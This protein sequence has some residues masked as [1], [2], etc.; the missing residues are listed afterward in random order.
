VIVVSV[1]PIN[2]NNSY[3]IAQLPAELC[4]DGGCEIG[5]GS[6]ANFGKLNSNPSPLSVKADWQTGL[7][8][9][10]KNWS[11][12]FTGSPDGKKPK[13]TVD[14][15]D[16]TKTVSFESLNK[17]WNFTL[18]AKPEGSPNLNPSEVNL[19]PAIEF[20][21]SN[22]LSNINGSNGRF[23][24][25]TPLKLGTTPSTLSFSGKNDGSGV[26]VQG[27][28]TIPVRFSESFDL[29]VGLSSASPI[30]LSPTLR[31]GVDGLPFIGDTN[32]NVTYRSDNGSVAVSFTPKSVNNITP[33][34]SGSSKPPENV[35]WNI[36]G[37]FPELKLEN[38]G[39]FGVFVNWQ[40]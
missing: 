16:K 4:P 13:T 36:F 40:K 7:E 31:V 25:S 14:P 3:N 32:I 2:N 9:P 35:G 19:N 28:L 39:N 29:D 27:S 11:F 12:P 6:P 15:F 20:T 26:N 1:S 17:D 10:P 33:N 8:P 38:T 22:G 18:K 23:D 30:F 34:N 5:V 21:A 37:G 24:F